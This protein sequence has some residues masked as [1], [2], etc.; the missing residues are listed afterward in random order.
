MKKGRHLT[1]Y[2]AFWLF[3]MKAIELNR[4]LKRGGC[5]E[6]NDEN[7]GIV[8]AIIRELFLFLTNI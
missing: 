1:V 7:K 4:A 5:P 8:I 3:E 2:T 6:I